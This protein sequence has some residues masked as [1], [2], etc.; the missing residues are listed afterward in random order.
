MSP[1]QQVDELGNVAHEVWENSTGPLSVIAEDNKN[2]LMTI[3][4]PL[5]QLRQGLA[6][7]AGVRTAG[8]AGTDGM[9]L[10]V[11]NANTV[12]HLIIT[13]QAA[14][15]DTALSGARFKLTEGA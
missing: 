9:L 10:I 8:M 11:P 3:N 4:P 15:T 2:I 14:G 7:M 6:F 13:L 5:Y 1:T 12:P